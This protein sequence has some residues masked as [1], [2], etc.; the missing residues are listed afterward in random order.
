MGTRFRDGTATRC[1]SVPCTPRSEKRWKSAASVSSSPGPALP[2][3]AC[4]TTSRP[5][6][7]TPAASV[8]S[9]TGRLSSVTPT[10]RRLQM[11]CWFSAAARTSTISHP[12]AALGLGNLAQLQSREWLVLR[13]SGTDCCEHVDLR[14]GRGNRRRSPDEAARYRPRSD[15]VA[16]APRRAC[17]RSSTPVQAA[18][19]SSPSR[20]GRRRRRRATTFS[21]PSATRG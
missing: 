15:R 21:S 12:S 6:A 16:Y 18:T 20:S 8:P 11:S 3:T 19:R 2:S 5:S 9:T 7:V 4:T 14:D 17:A 10:P 13:D 1:A